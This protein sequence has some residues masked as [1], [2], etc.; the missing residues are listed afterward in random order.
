V[1]R[2]NT[3]SLLRQVLTLLNAKL[4]DE[5][6]RLGF[7][8]EP[9]PVINCTNGELWLDER[10]K[11]KLQPHR[12]E[13][14]LRHCLDVAYD[15]EAECPEYDRAVK[16]IFAK[17][18]KPKAMARHWNDLS[19]YL[20][21]PSR[22]IP[23]ILL[24]SGGGDNGKTKLITTVMRLLGTD[25]VHAQRVE[26]LNTNR[27]AIGSLFGKRLF[28]DD[29]VKQ[30]AKLPDG[31]L[32]MISEEKLVSGE[33]KYKET[34]NFMVRTVPVLLCNNTPSLADWACPGFVER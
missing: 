8:A 14:Y 19:G 26:D 2:Q 4:A 21:Q 30:G 31:T 16:E 15:P 28:V 9:L 18:K 10:G 33:L 5:T 23:I 32:K 1:K 27:F 7:L 12:P 22:K 29:D 3:A 11:V 25:L 6:D 24:L 34:F 17:T 13:S 20:I